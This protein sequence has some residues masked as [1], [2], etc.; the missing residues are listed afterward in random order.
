MNLAYLQSSTLPTKTLQFDVTPEQQLRA[1]LLPQKAFIEVN[2][3][4]QASRLNI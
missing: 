2:Q 1:V 4:T 3:K